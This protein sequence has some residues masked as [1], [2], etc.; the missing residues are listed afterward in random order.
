MTVFVITHSTVVHTFLITVRY[1][2]EG[3]SLRLQFTAQ[4]NTI[5]MTRMLRDK[6]VGTQGVVACYYPIPI[7]WYNY[8][9]GNVQE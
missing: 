3:N 5:R 2:H 1:L 7:Q 9:Q 8:D 4:H 6:N